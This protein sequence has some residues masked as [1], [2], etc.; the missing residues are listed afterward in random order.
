M[1]IRSLD[2]QSANDNAPAVLGRID[3]GLQGLRLRSV[4]LIIHEG[5]F[6]QIERREHLRLER[7]APS[8]GGSSQN[9]AHI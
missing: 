5:Q 6:G 7:P 4:G 9:P 3:L 1:S 8:P 2:K